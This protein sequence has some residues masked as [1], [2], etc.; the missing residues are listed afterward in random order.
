MEILSLGEKI[1]KIRKEKDLTLKELAGNRITAAQISHIERDKSY[2][3]QDLLEYFVDKLGVSV[4][5]LLE[6]KEMQAKKICTNLLL[7]GEIFADSGDYE[8]AKRETNA[9]IDICKNYE[10]SDTYARAKFLLGKIYFYQ[11][12]YKL[13]IESLEKSLVYNVKISNYK[14]V[15][16]C[17]LEL[18]KIYMEEGYIKVAIDKFIQGENVFVEYKIKDNDIEK[19]I[20]T[21]MSYGY[22]KI[23]DNDNSLLYANKIQDM[24]ERMKN[25]TDKAN[26]LLLIGSNLLNMG[27]YDEAKEH[28]IKAKKIYEEENKKNE[29]AN[30]Q[31]VMSKIY[32]EMN[33]FEEAL[34]YVKKAY[35]IKRE[36]ED[37]E[38]VNVLFEYIKAFMNVEDFENAKKYSKRALAI[39]IKLKEKNLEYNSLKHYA[40]VFKREGDFHTAI[41]N[42]EKCITVLKSI[43][44][45][46][47]LADLYIEIGEI[48]NGI[49]KDKEIEYYTKSISIYK[50]LGIIEK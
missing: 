23:N 16:K 27:N 3:S 8:S 50:D 47:E 11:K 28:L 38:L 20:F 21:Y 33:E 26:S 17:Y 2:P 31:L 30:A 29:M 18:G 37:K 43:D 24:E 13:A 35:F 41:E 4:D 14:N 45:K 32:R 15:A 49:S 6:S 12:N 42:F 44:N 19:E 40:K 1:K 36:H 46:K 22:I 39:S 48:Y 10:M 9:V 7:K 25:K 34:E 5:Y